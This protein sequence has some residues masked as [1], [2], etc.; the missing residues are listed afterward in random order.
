M[1]FGYGVGDHRAFIIDIPIESLVGMNPVKIVRPSSRGLN[2]HL[3]GCSQAYIDSLKS[4]I[5]KHQL[6]EWLH[7]AHTGAYL[8]TEQTR[9]LIIINKEGKVYMRRAEKVCRK[10][11]CCRIPFS[12]EAAIWICQVQVYHSLLRFHKGKIKNQGNLKQTA[13]RCD[14]PD[15]LNMSIQEI[16][17]MLK[18]C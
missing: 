10:I 7:D 12:P 17:H 11:K 6:L 5:I 9:Q 2:S 3:P 1:P 8:A 16:T 15:P 14:I 13:R 18:P 4:N